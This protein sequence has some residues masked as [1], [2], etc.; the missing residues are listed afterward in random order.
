[1]KAIATAR[2]TPGD[3]DSSNPL[4]QVANPLRRKLIK[5]SN[6]KYH[7]VSQRREDTDDFETEDAFD[8]NMVAFILEF[9]PDLS[10]KDDSGKSAFDWARLTRNLEGLRL[11]EAKEKREALHN[12]SSSTR[13]QRIAECWDILVLNDRCV[14]ECSEF[15]R[16]SSFSESTFIEFLHKSTVTATS[17]ENAVS[18][19]R[20]VNGEAFESSPHH[21]VFY[22]NVEMRDG[23]TPLVKCAALGFLIAV[24]ELLS[25]GAELVHETRLRHTAMT[26]ACYCGHEAVVL[27]FLRVGVDVAKETREGRTALIHAVTNSQ[28]KI[29]HHL[30]IALRCAS[31][32]TIPNETY[33]PEVEI[34]GDRRW[35]EGNATEWHETFLKLV[36]MTD[37]DGKSALDYAEE[38]KET[39][40][41]G[42]QVF[43]Q[44]REAID[45]ASNY[46]EYVLL[47]RNRTHPTQC[48]NNGCDFIAPKDV[49]PMHEAH[50]CIKRDVRCELCNEEFVYETKANHEANVCLHRMVDCPNLQF[51]CR[52]RIKF[53][54]CPHHAS[55]HCRKRRVSC[56]RECETQVSY[57]LLDYHESYECSLRPVECD[58]GCAA[59]FLARDAKTHRLKRCPKRLIECIGSFNPLTSVKT[60]GT[61]AIAGCGM[62]IKFEDMA[63]HVSTLCALRRQ[64]CKWATH[65]CTEWIGGTS[66]ARNH[67]E[68]KE[69][70]FRLIECRHAGCALSGTIPAYFIDNHY[71]W[72][73]MLEPKPC[74]NACR[75]GVKGSVNILLSLPQHLHAV[76]GYEDAG[77]CP[78]RFT[79]C[80]LDM[81]GKKISL[82]DSSDELI[83]T[84]MSSDPALGATQQR[85]VSVKAL[86]ERV[87]HHTKI[88]DELDRD[89]SS[90]CGSKSVLC[91]ESSF[92][93][94]HEVKSFLLQWLRGSLLQLQQ[95]LINVENVKELHRVTVTVL[96]FDPTRCCHLVQF[97]DGRSA[98]RS[99]VRREF[100]ILDSLD[101]SQT[102][103]IELDSANTILSSNS[104][105]CG[106]IRANE[107]SGHIEAECSHRLV[108]CPLKCGQRLSS[109][110]VAVHTN[111]RCNLR[112]EFCR[113]GCGE[114]MPFANL[115]L[116]EETKCGLRSMPCE[117]CRCMFPVQSMADHLRLKC[118]ALF[119]PCRLGCSNQ[120]AWR[121]A[122][123]HEATDCAKRLISCP[124]CEECILAGELEN[125]TQDECAL[126][127][128]GP[129]EGHCGVV[130]KHN[131]VTH[132]LLFE[133]SQRIVSCSFCGERVVFAQLHQHKTL[134]CA[135]RLVFCRRG[136]GLH[137]KDADADAHENG[138]C[139]HRLGPCPNHCGL[140]IPFHLLDKH[141]QAECSMR[142]VECPLGCR[143]R[144]FAYLIDEHW[145]RCRQRVVPCGTGSKSCERPIRL[146]VARRKIIYCS[147]HNESALLFAIKS[148]DVDL[149][150]Y[151]LQNVEAPTETAVNS[152]FSSNGFAPLILA[153]ALGDLQMAELLLRFGASVNLET[154]RGRTALGEAVMV[155]D[156]EMVALLIE[157]RANVFHV[158]RMGRSTLA[159]ACE[160]ALASAAANSTAAHTKVSELLETQ[161]E[162]E[163]AQRALF[164]A[165]ACSDYNSVSGLLKYGQRPTV[166]DASAS[167]LEAVDPQEQ[168]ERELQEKLLQAKHA[169]SELEVAVHA[170]DESVADTEAKTLA[171]TN[172]TA[173]VEDFS[174]QIQRVEQ[175][176]ESSIAESSA[177]EVDMLDLIR[178]I[179]AQDVA[180]LLSAQVPSEAALVVMKAICLMCG[181]LPRGRRD[182]TEYSDLEWWKTAQAL[183]MDRS[184]L[185]KLRSYRSQRISTDVMAKV[186]RE[187]I[188]S[189]AFENCTVLF[190]KRMASSKTDLEAEN[191]PDAV[192]RR[193]A[194]TA[195]T[196]G[197]AVRGDLVNI[198]AA[199]VKGVEREYRSQSDR[200]TFVE[201]KRKMA[202]S[203]N[204]TQVT[205]QQANFDMQVATRSLPAR[206]L[207]VDDARVEFREA[208]SQLVV[209]KER[210][211]VH[212]LLSYPAL[213]GHTPLTFASAIGNEAMVHLLLSRGAVASYSFEEQ[214]L[215][216][217][218]LQVLV[219][220]FQYRKK[221][222]QQDSTSTPANRSDSATTALVRNVAHTFLLGHYR[223][224]LTH[225]RQTHRVALHEAVFN[226]F[227]DIA[228]TLLAH[229][230]ALWQRSHIFPSRVFPCKSMAAGT[231]IPW[232]SETAAKRVYYTE[233]WVLQPLEAVPSNART[234]QEGPDGGPVPLDMSLQIAIQYY[235]SARITKDP[236]SL[237]AASTES[238]SPE[239]ELLSTYFGPTHSFVHAAMKTVAERIA[240]RRS[241][242]LAR[243]TVA[244]KTAEQ[245]E[246]HSRLEGAIIDRDFHAVSELLGRGALADHETRADG[247]TALM[248]A[249]IE[250]VYVTNADGIDVLAVELLLA[251]TS[252][253]P[254]VNFESFAN[255]RTAL[256]TCARFDT[257]KC[258]NVLLARGARVNLATRRE[259]RT[260]LME[261]A[262]FGQ[263]EFIRW[264][265]A[266]P[267]T[268]VH[269]VDFT[270]RSALDFA[271]EARCVESV[272]I[273]RAAMTGCRGQPS[274]WVPEE[275]GL[276]PL[277]GLCKWGCGFLAVREDHEVVHAQVVRNTFPLAT[278]EDCE[279]P[280]R[281]VECRLGCGAGSMNRRPNTAVAK[282]IRELL[283]A[284]DVD[285]HIERECPLQIVKCE[286]PKC[287]SS[288]PRQNRKQHEEADC[289]FRIVLCECGERM[290]YQKNVTH[291]K[292][293]C[294]Q[295]LVECPFGCKQDGKFKFADLKRH[296][297]NECV[298][299]HVRCRHGCTKNDLI[300]QDRELHETRD[301]PLRRVTCRWRC[302]DVVLARHQLVHERDE[303]DLREVECTSRCGMR[304]VVGDA[305]DEHLRVDC[306]KRLT[307]CSLGC[308]RRVS[309][310][311][312]AIHNAK[313]CRKRSVKC[314][315]CN[316]EMAEE[317][318]KV[319]DARECPMRHT[320]CTLCGQTALTYSDLPSHRKEQCR[321]RIVECSHGCMMP[322]L[323]ALD[324]ERHE[325]WECKLRSIWCPLG[326]EEI[327]QATK[328]RAHEREECAMRFVTC[329]RGCG[330]E[331]RARDVDEHEE[332]HC[333]ML[334]KG[335][336]R[337]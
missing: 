260:A 266:I 215:C 89:D 305:L 101:S 218:F 292:S 269:A 245:R 9:N 23:W 50:Y 262:R 258:A 113:L 227:P 66:E 161:A 313:E 220:D 183:L 123:M 62:L 315:R 130:L 297:T 169:H 321:M 278:H 236:R 308:G 314:S 324:Q 132:H 143:E 172:L 179:T 73:C 229:G 121:D 7:P 41:A 287:G 178:E 145:K 272:A 53:L 249:C 165:I 192:G 90:D 221:R 336:G 185:R 216:A 163:R 106:F 246:L 207:E 175:S 21:K 153:A 140:D 104:F 48:H 241:D 267:D 274:P 95:E 304:C 233:G 42:I 243:K 232:L 12:A 234:E 291:A 223:R 108:L 64:Q 146:W 155:G 91:I 205:L 309:L 271:R 83:P 51:G 60:L 230:A 253:N 193:P 27:H 268:D 188:R 168:L 299:R 47:H 206:Q 199:W 285:D 28:P 117:H 25:M 210:I 213:S 170:F 306:T 159:L 39:S 16:M 326:C 248:A 214:S 290:T 173:K 265:L 138:E 310:D 196:S 98:W 96:R 259:K 337:R 298:R 154:S 81:C 3:S 293:T 158:N 331:L 128:F 202:L 194:T 4:P 33:N 312:M 252:N 112:N 135:Q 141:R 273:L 13:E 270:G 37:R 72:Q 1:M 150:A 328:L 40:S 77:E 250:E 94:R 200:Q 46:R 277:H 31:F 286:N 84:L 29:V 14:A 32:P 332:V 317:D 15:M 160:L 114:V 316:K 222:K 111:K 228:Q 122:A 125:H 80:P 78:L 120:V 157:H 279:C 201:R 85:S 238:K 44:I 226:G 149:V 171:A 87:S 43:K 52:E 142:P 280:K 181:A 100:D 203:L 256:M 88:V 212:R 147:A 257:R 151:F 162:L 70:P 204:A 71:A 82:Y 55:L 283:L 184:L 109:N 134:V 59:T 6:K 102:A 261:A 19:L 327:F 282:S 295:R 330:A 182:A 187:C 254:T 49:L 74:K 61:K 30:L 322:G 148:Q 224:K 115:A 144:M 300:F 110:S 76:H 244:R 242:V 103:K 247:T 45:E 301:C 75:S 303:C 20:R 131:Q 318:Q 137:L 156:A 36:N 289:E 251:R 281:L 323:R 126:R 24:Q 294:P 335:V 152:E 275:V 237:N 68:D 63:L 186:R 86:R 139:S 57:D 167:K 329:S 189:Q 225:F 65:G 284:E 211:K 180:T 56:R 320:S 127:V 116:H 97:P 166:N 198:L 38:R 240:Q 174:R 264:L 54:D 2:S 105:V 239:D 5:Y 118:D 129:C 107:I 58:L 119:R 333:P 124:K 177:L 11:L 176:H 191:T 288:Y 263:H 136:C 35:R 311:A 219:R 255:A 133:C 22:I 79:R 296:Q 231:T 17:F 302:G 34:S 69:C 26:W 93:K 195:T 18:D 217:S 10:A 325:L 209:A 190:E 164:V 276:T 197:N 235:N 208:E 319:H 67:H 307:H 92:L 99:L 334:G 8:N